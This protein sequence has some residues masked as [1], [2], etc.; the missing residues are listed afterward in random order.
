M[1]FANNTRRLVGSKS[2]FRLYSIN[3]EGA[4]NTWVKSTERLARCATLILD[5]DKR[6]HFAS[7]C[8]KSHVKRSF[9]SRFFEN[10]DSAEFPEQNTFRSSFPGNETYRFA[11]LNQSMSTNCVTP[12][13][14][15]LSFWKIYKQINFLSPLEHR[16]ESIFII[17]TL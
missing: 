7:F 16:C 9:R 13:S 10:R 3:H 11:R 6:P 8:D 17:S 12:V 4:Y 1:A 15:S 2:C 14:I 5:Y